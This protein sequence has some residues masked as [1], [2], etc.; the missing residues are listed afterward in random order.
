MQKEFLTEIAKVVIKYFSPK[1]LK[2]ILDDL[3][4]WKITGPT[5]FY[6]ISQEKEELKFELAFIYDETIVDYN[7]QK[8]RKSYGRF[9]FDSVG[10]IWTTEDESST[11]LYIRSISD[12]FLEYEASTKESRNKLKEFSKNLEKY[13]FKSR[14]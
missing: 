1:D 4:R 5:I 9:N 8:S 12:F 14:K 10:A 2:E 13:I 3:K 6:Q 7:F 11:N